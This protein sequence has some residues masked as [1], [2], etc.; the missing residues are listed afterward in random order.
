[1]AFSKNNK[2]SK[3]NR[4]IDN[5]VLEYIKEKGSTTIITHPN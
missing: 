3:N 5:F 1:M 2:L 4:Y